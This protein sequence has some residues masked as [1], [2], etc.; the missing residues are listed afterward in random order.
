MLEKIEFWVVLL[1]MVAL[2]VMS[3]WAVRLVWKE[4]SREPSRPDAMPPD[5]N[6]P[7]TTDNPGAGESAT[8]DKVNGVK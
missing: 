7:K 2:L 5:T 4:D 8:S 3:V 6:T 1:W